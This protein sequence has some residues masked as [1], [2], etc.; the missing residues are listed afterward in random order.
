MSDHRK[1]DDQPG[2][3]TGDINAGN[4]N[5]GEQTFHGD[6]TINYSTLN[7][8]PSDPAR[9]E[10][11]SLLK[12]LE[13]ALQSVPDDKAEEV[14]AVQTLANQAAS[15]AAKEQPN[16]TMLK[17]TG[18]GLKEAAQNLLAV[19]P[20]AVKIANTHCFRLGANPA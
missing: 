6:V 2:I 7:N 3:Q 18:E 1:N 17:V 20:I 16:K 19:S 12:Q 4:L 9:E 10:L 5:F 15:E 13:A 11:Q 8:A 14:E